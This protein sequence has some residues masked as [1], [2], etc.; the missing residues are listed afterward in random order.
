MTDK[1][2]ALTALRHE[3]P[4][5][6]PVDYWATRETDANLCALLGLSGR[7]Q[8]LD[9]FGVDFCYIAGPTYIGPPLRRIDE[10]TD[11]DLWGVPRRAASAASGSPTR[12]SSPIH[13]PMPKA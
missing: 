2:R 10:Q 12:T 3:Q 4:D 5:R 1:E 13:W 7:Q 6:V 11:L 8:I 9:H